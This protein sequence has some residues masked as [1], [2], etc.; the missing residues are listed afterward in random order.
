[1]K[2]SAIPVSEVAPEMEGRQVRVV[3]RVRRVGSRK[4]K[5]VVGSFS[6]RYCRNETEFAQDP[7]V[8]EV[9]FP[10]ACPRGEGGCGASAGPSQFDLYRSHSTEETV[11]EI[12]LQDRAGGPK[13]RVLLGEGNIGKVSREQS[14]VVE[15][16]L[17][18]LRNRDDSGVESAQLVVLASTIAGLRSADVGQPT[19]PSP[20]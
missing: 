19:L 9:I 8:M 10:P 7:A 6:C 2:D 18:V 4:A 16:T 17:R 1:M 15:G 12:I 13:I 5:I 3:G 14:A 20:S 11:Q